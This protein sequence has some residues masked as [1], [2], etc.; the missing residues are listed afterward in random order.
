MTCKMIEKCTRLDGSGLVS[1]PSF[2]CTFWGKRPTL[3]FMGAVYPGIVVNLRVINVK[4]R[5]SG[6]QVLCLDLPK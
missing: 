1:V 5:R 6:K 3:G 4:K 2:K